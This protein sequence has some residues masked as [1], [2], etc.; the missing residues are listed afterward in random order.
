MG[1]HKPSPIDQGPSLS[2]DRDPRSE[3]DDRN[4]QSP[5]RRRSVDSHRE[6]SEDQTGSEAHAAPWFGRDRKCI[7]PPPKD[8]RGLDS[9]S[10]Q[11]ALLTALSPVLLSLTNLITLDMS[12][13]TGAN[14]AQVQ[15]ELMLCQTWSKYCGLRKV[16]FPSGDVWIQPF[17]EFELSGENGRWVLVG[18]ND[19]VSPS[20]S[21]ADRS[22]RTS[23]EFAN[24]DN[25]A[26]VHDNPPEGEFPPPSLTVSVR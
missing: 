2:R 18:G 16:V 19:I 17:E 12:P 13:T 3:R 4:T 11:Q 21:N 1:G 5:S 24:T 7:S 20:S 26:G 25:V 10:S 14:T 22:R 8:I 15:E 9:S 23:S 6:R